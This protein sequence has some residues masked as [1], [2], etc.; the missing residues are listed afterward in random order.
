M[1]KLEMSFHNKVSLVK[2]AFRILAGFALIV[3]WTPLFT[4]AGAALIFAEML[5]VLE[6]IS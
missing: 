3:V 2:S 1:A 4:T 5:G 6:E